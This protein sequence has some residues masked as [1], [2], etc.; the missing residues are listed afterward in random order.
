MN[1][2]AFAITPR[3]AH[4]RSPRRQPACRPWGTEV[5]RIL[6]VRLDQLGDVLMTTPAMHALRE[7]AP[8]RHI[9]LLTSAAGAAMAPYLPDVDD[10][11]EYDAPWAN[12]AHASAKGHADGAGNE[13]A[14]LARVRA[15]R[16]DAAAIFTV[17][18]QNPLP[19]ATLCFFAGIERRL[20]H[21]RENPY[22]LLTNWLP[23]REP[24]TDVR[25]EVERQLALVRSVGADLADPADSRMRMSVDPAARI[26]LA[27]KLRMYGVDPAEPCIVVHAGA[28]A[29]SRR[30]PPA[31]FAEALD[32]LAPTVR[33]PLLLTGS[34]GESALTRDVMRF[35]RSPG[36]TRLVDL[37][38]ALTL[39]ELIALLDQAS[40][41]IANNSGPAHL[42]AALG[43]P[44]VDLYALTNPQH[45]PW[46][47]PHRLLYRDVA[48]RWCYRGECPEGHH[49]CLRGVPPGD[50]ARAAR[51]LLEEAGAHAP[52][53][54]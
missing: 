10:V 44:V 39:G 49:A 4:S 14:V 53:P 18:S 52:Q 23:E 5:R 7:S 50:V 27:Q 30:Y 37:A 36:S 1:G 15:G 45:S 24:Q 9:T 54:A 51:E 22:A 38:G 43:K 46:M 17:Y 11:I 47:T 26:T 29:P 34:L 2:T 19:A 3:D 16:F 28:S 42:A 48:C 25:H 31:L 21:C 20:A 12:G 8:R 6:C 13:D 33:C 35:S 40:L 32:L 41:L